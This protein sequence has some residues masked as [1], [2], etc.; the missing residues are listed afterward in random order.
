ME[1]SIHSLE[2]GHQIEEGPN[3]LVGPKQVAY[4]DPCKGHMAVLRTSPVEMQIA[5]PLI[6]NEKRI[7][8]IEEDITPEIHSE[9][10][11]DE[12]EPL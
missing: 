7:I 1:R 5:N 12:D 9:T 2:C 10:Q 11:G 8:N 4:C 3:N 6:I